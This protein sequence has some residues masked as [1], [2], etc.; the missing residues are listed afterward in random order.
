MASSACHILDMPVFYLSYTTAISI[1]KGRSDHPHS[2]EEK[3]EAHRHHV[4]DPRTYGRFPDPPH[5]PYYQA[6][7]AFCCILRSRG[8]VNP[9]VQLPSGEDTPTCWNMGDL[10]QPTGAW[11]ASVWRTE[12]GP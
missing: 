4:P 12:I 2:T 6:S 9:E 5:L 10:T 7:P 3:T 11:E 1:L 8:R